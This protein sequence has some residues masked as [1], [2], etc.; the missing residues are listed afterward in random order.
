[1]RKPPVSKKLKTR[2]LPIEQQRESRRLDSRYERCPVLGIVLK[3]NKGKV[4]NA[5]PTI[6]RAIPSRGYVRGNIDVISHKA[7][8]LKNNETNP[9]VFDAIAAYLRR[10]Q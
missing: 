1:M 7:N 3:A 5:S 4:G 6:D 10:H 2:N 9:S 8:T